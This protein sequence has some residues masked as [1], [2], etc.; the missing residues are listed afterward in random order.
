MGER[1]RARREGEGG[2]HNGERRNENWERGGGGGG[3]TMAREEMKIGR[4]GEGGGGAYNGER[5][6]ENWKREEGARREGEREL[7]EREGRGEGE[8]I[9]CREEK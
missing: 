1:G 6:N 7:G 3:H 8:S 4:E 9:Q 2:A 5:R